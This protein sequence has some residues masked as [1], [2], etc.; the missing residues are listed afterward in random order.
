[1]EAHVLDS[2]HFLLETHAACSSELIVDFVHRA[3]LLGARL[4]P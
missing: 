2:P 1:M 3:A 4:R